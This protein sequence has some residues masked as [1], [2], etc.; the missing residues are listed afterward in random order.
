M[1]NSPLGKL[2]E[3]LHATETKQMNSGILSR[4]VAL[5]KNAKP[6]ERGGKEMNVL[7]ENYRKKS[8]QRRNRKR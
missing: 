8:P 3:D 1:D 2:A 7:L 4:R 6:N 5:L